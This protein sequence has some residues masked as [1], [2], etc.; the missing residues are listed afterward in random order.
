MVEHVRRIALVVAVVRALLMHAHALSRHAGCFVTEAPL[1]DGGS[2]V[3]P[4]PT[5]VDADRPLATRR[6]TFIVCVVSELVFKAA[7][8][9][10]SPTLA[11][12]RAEQTA[13]G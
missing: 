3:Q 7:F 12:A 6:V 4:T 5:A 11:I 13:T 2:K 8:V 9:Q 10:Q 1:R